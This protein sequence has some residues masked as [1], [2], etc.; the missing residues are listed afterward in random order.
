MSHSNRKTVSVV[1]PYYNAA[2]KIGRAIQSAL[3]QTHAVSE[4]I[5]VDDCSSSEAAQTAQRCAEDTT[6]G[7]YIRLE[8]NGGPSVARN[9]GIDAATSDYIAF[10]DS[11]DW[12]LPEKIA[13]CL[14]AMNRN[15]G[16]FIGHN[17]VVADQQHLAISDKLR[18]FTDFYRMRPLDVFLSTS[19]F[20][21][22][23]VVFRRGTVP[24][25]FDENLRRSEDYRLWG[26]LI[27]RGHALWKAKAFLSGREEPHIKGGGL[28][29]DVTLLRDAHVQTATYFATTGLMSRIGAAA[30]SRFIRLKYLRH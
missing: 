22:T 15:G 25:R 24:V 8:R 6:C 30:L 13:F 18:P 26:E 7:R 16:D 1:I 21:P 17:N 5:V 27:L 20:A 2:G 10:L 28:S 11:D 4:I 9:R 3:N 14:N 29:G 23:S 19:Q 12:W